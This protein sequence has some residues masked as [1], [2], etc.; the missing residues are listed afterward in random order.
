MTGF[1][2][3]RVTFGVPLAQHQ[4]LAF[5]LADCAIQLRAA[6]LV[7]LDSA[8]LLDA[9]RPAR[10]ELAMA[11]VHTTETAVSV[12]DTAM[13][14]HGAAGFTNEL[15]LSEAWMQARAARVAD[16]T[17]EILRRQ[18]SR[19]LLGGRA[20]MPGGRTPGLTPRDQE[21]T[22][23]SDDGCRTLRPATSCPTSSTS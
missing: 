18:I 17:G 3:D 9:G 21:D 6:R 16:G 13:Q 22:A 5:S 19:D 4:A 2:A 10:T 7:S 8:R 23:C 12:I 11:K 14:L 20:E 15:G 1:V